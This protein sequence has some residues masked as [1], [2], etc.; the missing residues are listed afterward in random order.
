VFTTAFFGPPNERWQNLKDVDLK[1]FQLLPRA[2]LV[3]VLVYFGFVPRA[4]L[5]IINST[6]TALLGKF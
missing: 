1:G 4:M 3:A 2:I 5:D 6:T